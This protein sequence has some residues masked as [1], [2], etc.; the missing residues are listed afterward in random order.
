MCGFFPTKVWKKNLT[1][2]CKMTK[3]KKYH[4]TPL[5]TKADDFI[6]EV[7]KWMDNNLSCMDKVEVDI[8][9]RKKNGT[10]RYNA[11]RTF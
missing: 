6:E 7:A 3:K 2:L 1:L 4:E 8:T 5:W 10:S 11:E 9:I